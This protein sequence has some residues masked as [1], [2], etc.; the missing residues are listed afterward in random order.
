M[1][2]LPGKT[3]HNS[4]LFQM[5]APDPLRL[6][7]GDQLRQHRE[8]LGADSRSA[9][10]DCNHSQASVNVD[11]TRNRAPLSSRRL[12]IARAPHALKWSSPP[13]KYI[14]R[15]W[16]TIMV[17]VAMRLVT[18]ICL[19]LRSYSHSCSNS[20]SRCICRA[21][22]AHRRCCR[23]GFEESA[24]GGGERVVLTGRRP[25]SRRHLRP[26]CVVASRSCRR[27]YQTTFGRCP[28]RCRRTC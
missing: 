12:C 27:R 25:R 6:G 3:S 11:A 14:A 21:R 13:P 28:S 22:S 20:A 24:L 5:N 16:P 7:R 19:C 10:I 1:Q 9:C 18:A 15:C 23:R 8:G 2:H 26:R 4:L 17:K